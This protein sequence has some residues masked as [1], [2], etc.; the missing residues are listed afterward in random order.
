V[1]SIALVAC[2]AS[3]VQ[4]QK[5]GTSSSAVAV[6]VDNPFAGAVGY[7]NP[8]YQA[9]VSAFANQ[10]S[11]ATLKAKMATVGSY[12][13]AVW[14]D[15]IA[16]ITAGRGLAGHLDAA[17]AQAARVGAPVVFTFVVYD[18]PNRDCAALASNGEL[19]VAND[20]LAKYK[21][22]YVDP[23]AAIV[24]NPKYESLRIVGIVEPDSL[25]NLV[26]NTGLPTCAQAQSS[27]AY[28]QGIQYAIDKLNANPNVYLYLDAAH[29]AWLGW[30]SNIDPAVQLFTSTVQGTRRGLAGVD[31]FITNT[32]NYTPTQEPFMTATQTVGGNP[33]QSANFYQWNPHI[34]EATYTAALYAKLVAAGW[35]SRTGML[36]DT[37]RNGWGGA[38]RPAGAS[39]STDLNTFVNA[40]RIDR[41]PHRGLWCNQTGAGIG[42]PPQASPADFPASH[43]HAYVWIK[44]PGESDGTSD[45]VQTARPAD[46]NCDPAHMTQYGVLTNSLAGA[47]FAGQFFPAQ[48]AM[49]VQNA[50]PPIATTGAGGGTGG[51]TSGGGTGGSATCG[52]VASAPTGPVAT[53][54]SASQID[55]AWSAVTPPVNCAVT[56]DLFRGGTR[57]ATGLTTP[58]F[59][60]RGLTASTQYT[61]TVQA[62]DA[63][64]ASAA[65]AAASA[66]TQAAAGSAVTDCT[67][68]GTFRVNGGEY[69]IQQNEWNG[70]FGQC[71]SVGPGTRF[72]V[73]AGSFN[74]QGGAPA[75]Y[76]S[77]FK[78]CHW[79]NCSSAPNGMP[80][81]MSQIGSATTSWS[82]TTA[83][84]DWDV[85]YDIWF[86]STPTTTGQPDR[87]E[88]MVWIDHQGFPNPAGAQTA[89]GVSV[90]G[91]TWNVWTGTMPTWQIISYVATQ[92]V[93]SVADLDLLALMRD[94][95]GRGIIRPADYLIAVEAGFEI[96]TGG[97]G[98]T[99]NSFS[100]TVT[101]GG[102]GGGAV[103]SAA[104]AAPA[105]LTATA[106]S[107]SRIDLAWTA[108]APPAS[109]AVTYDLFRGT[110][111]IASG[112]TGTTFSDMG[113]AA[114][115]TYSYTVRATD[116]AGASAASGAAAATTQPQPS[117]GGGGTA[118]P[119]ANALDF[120]SNTGNFNTT[121]AVCYRTNAEINGWGCY[122]FDGRTLTVNG[123]T[124]SCGQL[125]L[126]PKMADGYRYFAATGGTFPWA[127]L[128]RW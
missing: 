99:T 24:A 62:V 117:G 48:F 83:P 46:P 64:G 18:L 9:E 105:G 123:A 109:C 79:G 28:V 128:Y 93:T 13:T 97:L 36:I 14:M 115:T 111:Q 65:S 102:G 34:G 114:A 52:A 16:A 37:S 29:S 110:T 3:Q 85:A 107:P 27:G 90:A 44:P 86:N 47:P 96:W 63:A 118:A 31:G 15:S 126:P 32:A 92:P 55:L 88:L 51:G 108:V 89:T 122:N 80:I 101:S 30:P 81:Q 82:V 67:Q 121:G 125:P 68:F 77:I 35:P 98:M 71:M 22:L 43:L 8:D 127:G 116:A 7:V 78:G 106:V 11:D 112:L 76:P 12:P 10:Q 75:T 42:V 57:V 100:A 58:S 119:C 6:H 73:T 2:N 5:T 70:N 53:V 87:V 25:P 1:A 113:L 120:G 94:A 74:N 17:L 61:Y 4:T 66:T 41:R 72:Q 45:T 49:L 91:R 54:I 59:S 124:V 103:C 38:A 33:V 26:T 56:Y 104:P 40:S 84:G 19:T 50:F 20:G 95:Q 21:T 39:A 69:V 23:I 60:D